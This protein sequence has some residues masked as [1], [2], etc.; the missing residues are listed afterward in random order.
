VVEVIEGWTAHRNLER[1]VS[2]SVA[3]GDAGEESTA[4]ALSAD[5]E[6]STHQEDLHLHAFSR[7]TCAQ[8][9]AQAWRDTALAGHPIRVEQS[10][11]QGSIPY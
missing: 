10:P 7:C 4:E 11:A 5:R 8:L 6:L 3:E 9:E 1:D 2:L